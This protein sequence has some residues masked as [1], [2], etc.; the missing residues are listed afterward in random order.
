VTHNIGITLDY[1]KV[2][3]CWFDRQN[4]IA[5]TEFDI[6]DDFSSFAAF[7]TALSRF[8][9]RDWGIEERFYPRGDRID[10]TLEDGSVV[11]IGL[12]AKPL[13]HRVA[14][15]GRG[16][17]VLKGEMAADSVTESVAV[18]TSYPETNR[19]SE[20]DFISKG[21]QCASN[22]CLPKIH[23]DED[24]GWP[25]SRIRERLSLGPKGRPRRQR[26]IV[27]EVLRCIDSLPGDNAAAAWLQCVH[28]HHEMWQSGCQHGD[29]SVYNLMYRGELQG[30]GTGIIFGVLNDWD[31][32]TL[33]DNSQG[34]ATGGIHQFTGT[35]PFAALDLIESDSQT[36]K[37]RH[38]LESFG[39]CLVYICL[40]DNH[41]LLAPWHDLGHTVAH[42]K[43]FLTD[44]HKHTARLGFEYLYQ[45]ACEFMSWLMRDV[46]G[47]LRGAERKPPI[48]SNN[49]RKE[50][51]PFLKL[52]HPKNIREPELTWQE[53]DD[54]QVWEGVLE[55]FNDWFSESS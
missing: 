25:T 22:I 31:L 3:V 5:T 50:F 17:M 34:Q 36:R 30:D 23:H 51:N 48:K 19:L 44:M 40:V 26:I 15:Q 49:A 18:K 20:R 43:A 53:L 42:R 21:A 41:A 46:T 12:Q 35:I 29:I 24:V 11:G 10:A 2:Q 1:N 16:T 54:A 7:I 13:C 33:C 45:F 37:Y 4:V 14:L 38:D 52:S 8:S 55:L 6:S 27:S 28:I 32:A 9:L 39:W 47:R